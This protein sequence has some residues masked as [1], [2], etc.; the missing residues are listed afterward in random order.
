M[1]KRAFSLEETL[2]G[3]TG[4][5]QL[6][7]L[8]MTLAGTTTTTTLSGTFEFTKLKAPMTEFSPTVTLG[9]SSECYLASLAAEIGGICKNFNGLKLR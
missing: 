4:F 7:M 1:A 5:L 9:L 8:L 3:S 6:E 2:C